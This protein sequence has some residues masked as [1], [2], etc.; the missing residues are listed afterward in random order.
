MVAMLKTFLGE[1]KNGEDIFSSETP[2]I[3]K[4][5]G[6][7]GLPSP[8][9]VHPKCGLIAAKFC[10]HLIRNK[11]PA[12]TQSGQYLTHA[13]LADLA[14]KSDKPVNDGN[15]DIIPET[16]EEARTRM[17]MDLFGISV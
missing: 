12:M 7:E 15:P 3:A 16:L 4:H 2:F 5:A 14:H 11:K 10:P 9:H 1:D 8:T 6:E 17:I 13:E